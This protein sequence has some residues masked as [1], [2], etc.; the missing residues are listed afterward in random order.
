MIF[1]YFLIT[2]V[3]ILLLALIKKIDVAIDLIYNRLNIESE[4]WGDNDV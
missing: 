2:L 4:I 1:I 3:I